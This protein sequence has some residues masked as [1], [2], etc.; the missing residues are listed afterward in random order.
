MRHGCY[1]EFHAL[2]AII[3]QLIVWECGLV[4][5][6]CRSRTCPIMQISSLRVLHMILRMNDL[7]CDTPPAAHV[8]VLT[9]MLVLNHIHVTFNCGEDVVAVP[10]AV[11]NRVTRF[12]CFSEGFGSTVWQYFRVSYAY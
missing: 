6:L 11:Y 2:Q 8:N 7:L 5:V 12:P 3:R 4:Y 10:V 1:S 9:Y